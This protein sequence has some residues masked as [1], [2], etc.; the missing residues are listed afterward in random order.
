MKA[1]LYAQRVI[2]RL[3][4]LKATGSGSHATARHPIRTMEASSKYPSVD[5]CG[6]SENSS[7]SRAIKMARQER[8][9]APASAMVMIQNRPV[10]PPDSTV[11]SLIARRVPPVGRS[12][13][14]CSPLTPSGETR[15]TPSRSPLCSMSRS[16]RIGLWMHP[17]GMERRRDHVLHR[18]WC[19]VYCTDVASKRMRPTANSNFAIAPWY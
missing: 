18:R 7:I 2:P 3:D 13:L 5:M 8:G 11:I 9:I 16:T 10:R 17:Q 12:F 15:V 6:S 19:R 1:M 14:R 4:S